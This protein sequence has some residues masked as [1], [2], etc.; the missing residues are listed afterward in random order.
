[1]R[2]KAMQNHTRILVVVPRG[3]INRMPMQKKESRNYGDSLL[4][5]KERSDA[6]RNE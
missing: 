4:V 2:G 6:R 3:D 1:M 5:V